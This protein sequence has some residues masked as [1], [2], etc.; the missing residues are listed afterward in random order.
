MKNF[1]S[2]LTTNKST[3]QPEFISQIK[4]AQYVQEPFSDS[5]IINLQDAFLNNGLHY[6]MTDNIPSG[7]GLINLFL[8]SLNYYHNIAALSLSDESLEN[9]ITDLYTQLI[10]GGHLNQNL[11]HELEDFFL[12]KFCYDFMWIEATEIFLKSFWAEELF[13]KIIEFKLDHLIPILVVSY[14]N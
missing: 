8:K 3:C 2:F 1:Q 6:I 14:K 9:N 13:K 11:S 10:L 4:Q 12:E 7:R 5:D